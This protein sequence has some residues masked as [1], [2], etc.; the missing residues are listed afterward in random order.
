MKIK[1]VLIGL[2]PKESWTILEK[3]NNERNYKMV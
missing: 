1:Y 3:S 2:G